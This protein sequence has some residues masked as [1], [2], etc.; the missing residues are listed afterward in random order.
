MTARGIPLFLALL[1]GW[2]MPAQANLDALSNQDAASGLKAALEKGAGAAVDSLGKTDGFFG[3]SAVKIPLPDSLKKYEK[4]MHTVGM[5]KYADELVL[6]MNRAAEQAVPEAKKLFTE[7]IKKMSVQDAKGILTGGQTSGTDYFKRTTSDQLREK[8]LPIVKQAT[9][10]VKLADKY[11]Q[12]AQKGAQFGLIKKDQ[13][14]LDDY[15]TQKSLDGLFY[16]VAEEE[17]KI[18]QNPVQAGSDIIK[19]VFGALK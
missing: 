8:F 13:A 6:T 5:G 17:K 9:A 1:L 12:Y 3:N 2:T 7:S 10:K 15:V 16:M 14:N 11:N 19:K 18:R 4:L